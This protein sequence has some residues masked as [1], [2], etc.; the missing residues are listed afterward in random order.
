MT[1]EMVQIVAGLLLKYGPAVAEKVAAL[2]EAKQVS[3]ADWEDVFEIS[4]RS[5]ESYEA[6][7]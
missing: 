6:G 7:K 5:Y 3:A 4:R 2:L 1:P